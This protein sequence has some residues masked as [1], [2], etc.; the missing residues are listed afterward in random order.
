MGAIAFGLG[1]SL[2]VCF[3]L[4]FYEKLY[5]RISAKWK[6]AAVLILLTVFVVD[7][8]Y[9]AIRPNVGSGISEKV[10][11]QVKMVD[12]RTYVY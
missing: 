11:E 9:S 12:E 7:A 2:L 3:L 4:P 5:D 6:T 10:Q 1:G 8:A